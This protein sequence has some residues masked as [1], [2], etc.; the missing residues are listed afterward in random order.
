MIGPMLKREGVTVGKTTICH[1]INERKRGKKKRKPNPLNPHSRR[2]EL[3]IP[4]LR[5]QVDVKYVPELIDGQRGYCY[6]AI[7]ECTRLRFSYTYDYLNEYST[8]DFLSRMLEAFS[9]PI[10]TIQTD[11]GFE[12]TFF[13]QQQQGSGTKINRR[14]HSM[15]SWCRENGIHHRLIPPGAKELNGKVERSHRIDEQYFYWK[16][17]TDNLQNFNQKLAVWIGQYNCERVHGGLGYMTPLEKLRERLQALQEPIEQDWTKLRELGQRMH[18]DSE[19]IR[20]LRLKF[21]EQTPKRL[22]D[23]NRQRKLRRRQTDLMATLEQELLKLKLV[24]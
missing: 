20:T 14:E 18:L 8:I 2:Y 5:V 10:H 4:G 21:L 16:A 15:A 13:L 24:A 1:V 6:V 9:F 12:F 3:P 22:A 17:P 11:N 19:Q 7:D 23:Q